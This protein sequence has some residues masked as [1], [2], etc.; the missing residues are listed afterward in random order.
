M[1]SNHD[2]AIVTLFHSILRD[3]L[4]QFLEFLIFEGVRHFFALFA[5]PPTTLLTLIITANLRDRLSVEL[6]RYGDGVVL[7]FVQPVEPNED[8]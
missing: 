4:D 5:Q 3:T 2:L 7:L 8:N 1:V 6:C